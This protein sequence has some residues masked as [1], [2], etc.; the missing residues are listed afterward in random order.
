MTIT[1]AAFIISV[2]LNYSQSYNIAFETSI[3]K[4]QQE[5]DTQLPNTFLVK[6][7][8]RSITFNKLPAQVTVVQFG[9]TEPNNTVAIGHAQLGSDKTLS[10]RKSFVLSSSRPANITFCITVLILRCLV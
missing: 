8:E 5:I 7:K 9:V 2:S 10:R 4:L 6:M 1:E 3:N